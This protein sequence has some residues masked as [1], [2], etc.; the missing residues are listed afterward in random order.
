DRFHPYRFHRFLDTDGLHGVL[1]ADGFDETFKAAGLP[2]IFDERLEVERA[3]LRLLSRHTQDLLPDSRVPLH[4]SAPYWNCTP[5]PVRVTALPKPSLSGV[6]CL[7]PP[8][9]PR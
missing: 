6:H 1:H 2:E 3:T 7:A 9:A 8:P 4:P 5:F